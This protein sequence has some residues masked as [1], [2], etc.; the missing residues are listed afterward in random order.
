MSGLL[1]HEEPWR[2]WHAAISGGRMHHAWL[3]TGPAGLGKAG[4][5]RAAAAE[6]VSE[7]GIPQPA[8]DQHPDILWLERQPASTDDEKKRDDGKP[9][10]TK[11]SITVDQVRAMQRRLTTRPT[12]G[13]KRVIV[14]DSADDLEKSAVNALLKSLEEPP[15]GSMFL[16]VSHRP[17]G[18][19]PTVRSRCRTLRFQPLVDEQ[20]ARIVQTARPDASADELA[21]AV[22]AAHGAPGAALQFI[23]ND[24]AAIRRE[25]LGI[26]EHGDADFTR[27]GTLAAAIGAR[28]DRERLLA[29]VELARAICAERAALASRPV[30]ARLIEAHSR[31]TRFGSEIPYANFDPGLAVV[32]IGGLLAAAAP[33]KE[34]AG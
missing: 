14:F 28:P 12:L 11:R 17:G 1:G 30:Q 2:E 6:M 15:M 7:P 10:K 33:P 19:L 27:R 16:L 32:E 21:A 9:F 3:L 31:L 5:A 23:D 24:L 8:W 4:F 18:L 26:I 34:M 25:L 22:D 13:S 29:S 20:I